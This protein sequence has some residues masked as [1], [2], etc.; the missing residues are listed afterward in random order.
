MKDSPG[1]E[2]AGEDTLYRVT[3]EGMAAMR[4]HSPKP[5][6]VSKAKRRYRAWLRSESSLKFFDWLMWRALPE[7]IEKYGRVDA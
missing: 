4:E 1:A 6:K 3:P 7:C 5:P 2:W